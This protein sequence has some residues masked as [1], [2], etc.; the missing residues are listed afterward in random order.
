[1]L[2]F[3]S[4]YFFYLFIHIYIKYFLQLIIIYKIFNQNFFITDFEGAP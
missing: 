1:M 3:Y 4:Y 2:K